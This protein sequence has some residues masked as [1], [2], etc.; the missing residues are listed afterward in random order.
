MK[1]YMTPR[2]KLTVVAHMMRVGN[3][4]DANACIPIIMNETMLVL[5]QLESEDR[6]WLE[7]LMNKVAQSQEKHDWLGFADYL[8]YELTALYPE[9]NIQ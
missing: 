7:G 6:R 8:E 2:E 4:A 1:D 3:L 5:E 9:K